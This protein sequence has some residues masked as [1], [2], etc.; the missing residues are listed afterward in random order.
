MEC[1]NSSVRAI[2]ILVIRAWA[3]QTYDLCVRTF[4]IVNIREDNS[5][6]K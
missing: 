1:L 2:Q 6:M 4:Q 5:K 3:S